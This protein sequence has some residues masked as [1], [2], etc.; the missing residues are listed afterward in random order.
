[1]L[2]QIDI[3]FGIMYNTGNNLLDRWSRSRHDI[4]LFILGEN[5]I[6]DKNIRSVLEIV[7]TMTI[8][9]SKFYITKMISFYVYVAL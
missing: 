5:R 4:I 9:E 1:M 3:D 6:K 7:K 2:F 8:S